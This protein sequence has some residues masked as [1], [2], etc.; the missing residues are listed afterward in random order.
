MVLQQFYWLGPTQVEIEDGDDADL[1]ACG[2]VGKYL[3][4]LG[5]KDSRPQRTNGAM[6]NRRLPFLNKG[7]QF[8]L[9]LV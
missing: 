3:S 8:V 1:D 9:A 4:K 6:K 2:R 5:S 7:L